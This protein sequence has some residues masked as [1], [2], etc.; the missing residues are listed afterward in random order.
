[1]NTAVNDF[2]IIFKMKTGL[3]KIILVTK[4]PSVV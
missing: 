1:M 2:Y 4:G 3:L